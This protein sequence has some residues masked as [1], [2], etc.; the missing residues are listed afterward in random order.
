MRILTEIKNFL[1][2]YGDMFP[3][4]MDAFRKVK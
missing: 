2:E 1:K 3:D 4:H